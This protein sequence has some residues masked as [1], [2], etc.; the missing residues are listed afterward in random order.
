MKALIPAIVLAIGLA[1]G[2][3][4]C[5]VTSGHET[6]HEYVDDAT[7]TSRVKSR[8]AKDPTVSAMRIH[9]HTDKGIVNLSGTA[10][11]QAERDQAGRLATA[12]PDVKSVQNDITVEST[13]SDTTTKR[14]NQ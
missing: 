14:S 1:G 4:G 11:S 5:S 6:A 13:S 3:T 2:V 10:K 12:V 7:V 9:V 8:F